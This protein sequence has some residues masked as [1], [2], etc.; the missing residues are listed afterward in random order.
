M[1]RERIF[2]GFPGAP[3]QGEP[4]EI[5]LRTPAQADPR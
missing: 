3:S 1:L 4:E 5:Q 2:R